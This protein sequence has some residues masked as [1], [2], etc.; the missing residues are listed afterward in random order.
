M[1]NT[2]FNNCYLQSF[3]VNMISPDKIFNCDDRGGEKTK[4]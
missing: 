3:V 4:T 1:E 2:D